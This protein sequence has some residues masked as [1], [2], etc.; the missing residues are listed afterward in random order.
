MNG[1][2]QANKWRLFDG[3]KRRAVVVVVDADT[4]A[5]RNAKRP[6]GEVLFSSKTVTEMKGQSG[7]RP[8]DYVCS[9]GNQIKS[10]L[11]AR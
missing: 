4:L 11:N 9:M 2:V 6:A 7:S 10:H 1:S 8:P 5:E 3:Y